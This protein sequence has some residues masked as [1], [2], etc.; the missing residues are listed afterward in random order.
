MTRLVLGGA[1]AGALGWGIRGQY[2]HETGAMIAGLLV[3]L[4]IVTC[5]RPRAHTH[6]AMRAVALGTVGVGFG[7]AMTYGQTIGLTQDAALVGNVAALRWGLFG[8]A[9]KGGLWIGLFGAWLAM[10]LGTVRYRG[11]EVLALAVASVALAALGTWL[12]NEPYAPEA[13]VLP[14]WYFSASWHWRPD[15][16]TLSPRREVWGGL[17]LALIGLLAYTRLVR[18]DRLTLRLAAWGVLGGAIGFPLGQAL[19]AWHAWHP[20]MFATGAWVHVDP[21]V[22]WWN[23]M[24]TTFGAV[25]G[26]TL[27]AGAWCH[28]DRLDDGS[29]PGEVTLATP[30]E[31][32]A[33]AAHTGLI[34]VAEF[35]DVPGLGRYADVPFLLGVLPLTLAAAGR[36]APALVALPITLLPIAGKTLRRHVIEEHA[37]SPLLGGLAYA[38]VPMALMV[39]AAWWTVQRSRERAPAW[40]VL[41]VILVLATWTYTL[42]NFAVFRYAWPWRAWTPRTLHALVFFV[43]AGGLTMLAWRAWRAGTA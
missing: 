17:L 43:C 23:L 33:L 22:N 5:L 12:L 29:A 28:R 34:V 36:L 8:L 15:A 10:G 1:A 6:W 42:L 41:P 26:A 7:G 3:A 13:R 9:I 18:H 35:T 40:R 39:V 25:M 31:V 4:V 11:R 30:L 27:A 14:R 21:F 37:L 19:Q 16:G 32:A 20:A 38:L 24:E 2:G